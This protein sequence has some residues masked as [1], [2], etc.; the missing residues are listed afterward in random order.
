[1]K[2]I[3]RWA[4][5]V[6]GLAIVLVFV[7][8]GAVI[9]GV[10]WMREH[11][12]IAD[13]N[14]AEATRAF[15][16]I[17]ARFPGQLPLLELRDGTPHYVEE[18]AS[19]PQSTTTITT[20]HVVAWDTDERRLVK[21]AVPWWVLRLKSGTISF[22]SYASGIDDA[23]VKLRPE[24]IERHGPG[25]LLDFTVKREGRVLIWTE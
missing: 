5:I 3:P 18:R 12:D 1:M 15:D 22:S 7:A 6:L 14:E 17:H 20:M 21:V 23:G 16:E 13:S 2:S 19:Q 24:D 4:Q 9:F 11:V 10:A 8:I 25:I